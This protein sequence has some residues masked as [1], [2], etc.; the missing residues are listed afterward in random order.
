MFPALGLK[1]DWKR[2][3]E[4]DLV[5]DYLAWQARR[6]LML[7]NIDDDER[8]WLERQACRQAVELAAG[9]RL[10]PQIIDHDA[11]EAARVEARLRRVTV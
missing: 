4:C 1:T 9:Y 6:L 7:Q 8:C 10:I 11:I 3:I 5:R 2:D